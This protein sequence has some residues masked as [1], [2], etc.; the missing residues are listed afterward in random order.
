MAFSGFSHL[1][2]I[3]GGKGSP[4]ARYFLFAKWTD[5]DGLRVVVEAVP[6]ELSQVRESFHRFNCCS[7]IKNCVVDAGIYSPPGELRFP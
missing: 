6:S 4:L 2:R 5:D 7:V 1:P 3:G